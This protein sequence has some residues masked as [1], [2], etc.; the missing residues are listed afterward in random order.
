MFLSVQII[1]WCLIHSAIFYF[2]GMQSLFYMWSSAAFAVGAFAHP[3][4][5]FWLIQHQCC[6]STDKLFQPTISYKGNWLWHMLN[7]GMYNLM[8]WDEFV[9][10]DSRES[11]LFSQDMAGVS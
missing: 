1:S 11:A 8:S 9:G 10:C 6:A 2:S 7:L 3:Y 4:I 5:L